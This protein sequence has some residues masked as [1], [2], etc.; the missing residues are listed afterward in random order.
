MQ[1]TIYMVKSSLSIRLSQFN[2]LFTVSSKIYN[3]SIRDWAK[4]YTR[5]QHDFWNLDYDKMIFVVGI[6][7]DAIFLTDHLPY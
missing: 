2:L 6:I 3:L 5:Q 7:C 1:R 4:S